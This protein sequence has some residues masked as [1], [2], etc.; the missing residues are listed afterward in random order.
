MPYK[1]IDAGG[2]PPAMTTTPAKSRKVR[3]LAQ[4]Y[5]DPRVESHSDE[6]FGDPDGGDGIWLYLR[7]PYFNPA[8]ETSCCHEWTVADLLRSLN[9][10]VVADEAA[11]RRSD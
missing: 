10:D 7:R 5:A 11:W 3:T 6:R 2:P 4:A 1:L 9:E 8:S